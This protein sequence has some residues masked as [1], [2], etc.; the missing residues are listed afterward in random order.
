MSTQQISLSHLFSRALTDPES[1]KILAATHPPV[2]LLGPGMPPAGPDF[3]AHAINMGDEIDTSA[4][5]KKKQPAAGPALNYI[6]YR[7]LYDRDFTMPIE[8][9]GDVF[10]AYFVP[11]H[12]AGLDPNMAR[13]PKPAKVMIV[14]KIPQREELSQKFNFVGQSSQ[15]LFSALAA[16]GVQPEEYD[17]WY[18]TNACK[19]GAPDPSMASIPAVWIKDCAPLLA[20]EFRLV[21]PDYILCLGVEATKAVLN[22]KASVSSLNGRAMSIK[23]PDVNGTEREIKVMAAMH[24]AYVSRKPEVYDEFCVQ[25]KRFVDL[26]RDQLAPAEVV[27]HA[28]IY[29]EDTLRRV[30]DDIIADTTPNANIIAVDCEW[31]GEHPVDDGA[32]LRTIQFSNKDKWA[33]TVVLRYDNGAPAF[34]PNL[35]AARVQLNRLLKSTPERQVR[36]GGHFLRAD[37]PWLLAFGVDARD[38]YAPS[39]DQN[40]RLAGGWD[41][42]LMYHAWNECAKY[43]LDECVMRFTSAPT[44]WAAL[45]RWKKEYCKSKKLKQAELGGYGACPT[46]VLHPYGNYDADVTR[47]IMMKFYGTDGTDGL[48]SKDMYG[49][50]CWVPYWI[51]HS[52][53]LAFLEMEQTGFVLDSNRVDE[54]TTMFMSAQEQMLQELRDV[55][56][57]PSFNPKSH[58]QTTIALFGRQ[59]LSRF[60][61]PIPIPDTATPLNLT[62]LKV[63]GKRP[64]LWA[65][66]TARGGDIDKAVPSTDRESLGILAHTNPI[67]AKFRDYKFISQV[68]QSVLRKPAKD[69][70][71]EYEVDDNGNYIYEKGLVGCAHSDGKIRTH[72]F[73]T[74]ETGRASSSRPPLQNLSSRR[75]ADYKR[76]F[77]KEAY[78]HPVRSILRVPEGYVGIE[79]DFTG[80]ELAVLAWLSQDKNFIEHV[81]R[82]LLPEEHPDHYDIHSQQAIRAFNLTGVAPTKK[83]ME[84]AGKKNLRVAAKNVNFGIPYGR[85]AEALARQCAEEGAP[86][87]IAEC[88]K[89]IEAYFTSYPLTKP[90]LQEC[91]DRSQN[92]GWL[93]GP[94]GR[95]RRFIPTTDRAIMGEQHRQ[96]QNFPIQNGVADAVSL[97][98]FNFQEYRRNHPEIVFDITM[99]IH[100]A[101]VLTT[102]LEH[103]ERVYKEVLPYCMVEA[104]PFWPRRLDGTPIPVDEPYRFGSSREVFVHWGEVLKAPQAEKLGLHWLAEELSVAP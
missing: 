46:S 43:G 104:V 81:R 38:E 32:Y 45:E 8:H 6:Y 15:P 13:G 62:P 39:R 64:I 61:K 52:A 9:K 71:G 67:A 75:E 82:N 101:I 59:F 11:G 28:D 80:A 34:K 74:K 21:K 89:M 12:I 92:P 76:I 48:L 55:L 72:L 102:P 4:K 44:Y 91:R 18:F 94:Y 49:N 79:A 14:G 87:S 83:G 37:L 41:T 53:S 69:D 90:F 57:W 10:T 20:A 99:Q 65:D 103:A 47:R 23:V 84:D 54:L 7:A 63:T 30:V 88:Q 97:A 85:G 73:Q 19:F 56:N 66:L 24:P 35:E 96:A 40:N 33:R 60:D 58:P 1:A 42:S 3:I 29:T 95:Y 51:S 26:M 78:K 93:V 98:L 36:I 25:I 16:A 17:H 68:L 86:V 50:D 22:T 70:D 5:G 31:H 27:D 100:D 77:G 2:D